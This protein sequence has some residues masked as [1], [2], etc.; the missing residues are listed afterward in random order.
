MSR[1]SITPAL[2]SATAGESVWTSMPSAAAVVQ[3]VASL[4]APLI[5]TM[6]MRQVAEGDKAGW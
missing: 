5:S 1:N 4:G 2:A 6:H 3:E